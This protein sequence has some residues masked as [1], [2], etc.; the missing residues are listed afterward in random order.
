MV[1]LFQRF[2]HIILS[3]IACISY[4]CPATIGTCGVVFRVSLLT[5]DALHASRSTEGPN[6]GDNIVALL[7][8]R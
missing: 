7:C 8:G 1:S 2:I 4:F 3:K 6:E 5:Y